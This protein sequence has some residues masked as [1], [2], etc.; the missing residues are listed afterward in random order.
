MAEVIIFI[1]IELTAII[2]GY[3]FVKSDISMIGV[4]ISVV[5]FMIVSLIHFFH[6]L[7]LPYIIQNVSDNITCIS[8]KINSGFK[9]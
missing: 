9:D 3:T 1:E 7:K 4:F 6:C 2:P 8:A 5:S